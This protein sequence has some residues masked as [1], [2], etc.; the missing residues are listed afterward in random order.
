MC[1]CVSILCALPVSLCLCRT[2]DLPPWNTSADLMTPLL[3]CYDSREYSRA[4]YS[5]AEM[6]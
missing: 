2:D 1:V 3:K 6:R 4:Q 5:T